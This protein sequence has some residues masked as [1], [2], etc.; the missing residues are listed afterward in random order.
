MTFVPDINRTP[1]LELLTRL[2]DVGFQTNGNHHETIGFL[3]STILN[4]LTRMEMNGMGDVSEKVRQR[5]VEV[6][7][8]GVRPLGERIG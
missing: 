1:T 5:I 2:V 6:T 4:V 8:N 7:N 3:C